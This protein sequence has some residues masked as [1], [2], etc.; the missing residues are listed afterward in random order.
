VAVGVAVRSQSPPQ[1][2]IRLMIRRGFTCQ[3][4]AIES[5]CVEQVCEHLENFELLDCVGQAVCPLKGQPHT[6]CRLKRHLI[7]TSTQ[8]H[9]RPAETEPE[10][11]IFTH[12][13]SF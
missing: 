11:T 1:S 2:V 8:Q 9:G 3:N 10:S 7:S 5:V 13:L 4:G 6:N 12:R